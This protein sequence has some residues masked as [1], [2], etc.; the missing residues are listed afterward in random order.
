MSKEELIKLV[1]RQLQLTHKAKSR[2]AGDMRE[3]CLQL[4]HFIIVTELSKEVAEL[5]KQAAERPQ[6]SSDEAVT[7]AVAV[8]EGLRAE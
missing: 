1:K 5:R 2:S 4:C 6:E 8:V 3:Y 7:E